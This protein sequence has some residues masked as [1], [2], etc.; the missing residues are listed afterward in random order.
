LRY[1]TLFESIDEGFCIID[2]LFDDAGRAFDYRFVEVNPAFARQS[3][4]GDAVGRTIRELVPGIEY[5]Y[6]ATYARVAL[7][8]EPIRFESH[9]GALHR[10]F[11]A[12]AFRIG[13][14]QLRR[15]ALLFTDITERKL[16][17]D[18]LQQRE[19]ELR[20]AQRVGGLGSWLWD[21]ASD[22]TEASPELL[23]IF[24]LEPGTPFPS[25]ADQCGT[26]Y[27]REEWERLQAIVQE[28]L[29]TGVPYAADMRALRQGRPIWVTT[30]GAAVRDADG[31]VLG[32][33][34]TLQ[35]IT[36]RK[37]IEQALR[38]ADARKDEFLATL[39]HE[40]RN[41]LAPLRNGLAILGRS[42]TDSTAAVRARQLMERQ[43]T[44]LVRL[45]D[46]L[47]DVSR[48]SQG[49]VTMKKSDTTLQ[50]VVDLA[51][52]TS[53]PLI[54]AAGHQLEVAL[55]AAPVPLHVD[56]TRVAQVLSNLLNNA[57]KYTPHGGRIRVDARV[58]DQ[59]LHLAVHDNGV[60][61]PP[62]M[63]ERV[64][65]LFTQVGDALERSQGGLGIGLSLARRLVELH[66]GRI[67]AESG[68]ERRGSTFVVELPLLLPRAET[69]P[70]PADAP[71]GPGPREGA[72]RRILVVDDNK[73]A[74][75]TMA[76][77]LELE[78]HQVNLAHT[79]QDALAFAVRDR[80]EVILL[81]IGLPDLDG[82]QVASRLRADPQL[83]HSLLV[84][85]T[86]W[87]G[88]R[89]QQRAREAG[90]HVHLTK[91]VTPADLARALERA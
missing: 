78:G 37:Q 50:A 83:A 52:E 13:E 47:L 26:H 70:D 18:A 79:G 91:P 63:L 44:H 43:L 2:V 65:D 39:A 81:D 23:R 31:K 54:D 59:T 30:R 82:Y 62:D 3:G 56:A 51:L 17:Q 12:F 10:W 85:L 6:I 75:E 45:V 16:A 11:D 1:R 32:L 68:G 24:G 34:G 38:E 89:D 20:E 49:K 77:L 19:L 74:A 27:P 33:R 46:D 80:P 25:F 66:G 14:P 67:R 69:A 29:E 5:D 71:A 7:T 60:G 72:S 21:A 41:P 86:G 84:A 8:G 76:M 48:V 55:P 58:M 4:L 42:G 15:V 73:D 9:A 57:A 61:I 35:D 53:R 88:E 87:G 36:D 90:F 22:H 28:A 40:L 64:F